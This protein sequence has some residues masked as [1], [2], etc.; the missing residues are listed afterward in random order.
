MPLPASSGYATFTPQLP[1]AIQTDWRGVG[2]ITS[3]ATEFWAEAENVDPRRARYANDSGPTEIAGG[4]I[5]Y[6]YA[7]QVFA[8]VY[9]ISMPTT[10]GPTIRVYPPKAG[11]DLYATSDTFGSD[12]AFDSGWEAFLPLVENPEDSAPQFLD[13]TAN[14]NHGTAGGTI[15]DSQKTTGGPINIAVNINSNQYIQIGTGHGLT[16]QFSWSAWYTNSA[17]ITVATPFPKVIYFDADNFMELRTATRHEYAATNTGNLTPVWSGAECMGEA[18]DSSGNGARYLDGV[19]A[20]FTVGTPALT[21]KAIQFPQNSTESLDGTGEAM[22]EVHNVVRDADW[23]AYNYTMLDDI[24]TYMG[25]L[26]WTPGAGGGGNNVA[27][28]FRN[29]QRM[30]AF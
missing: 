1:S 4:P 12:N 27:G 8:F 22:I 29:Y 23:M 2:I 16:N 6:D 26:S 11:N 18:I 24:A 3:A 19:E 30:R 5:F 7:T 13:L 9:F 28:H 10:S 25:A 21:S 14:G 20:T 15:L 17:G